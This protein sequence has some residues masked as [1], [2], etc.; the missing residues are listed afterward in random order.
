MYSSRE[1]TMLKTS[2][3]RNQRSKGL[4][5]KHVLQIFV[6]LATSLWLVNQLKH[7]YDKKE[8]F[9]DSSEKIPEEVR[10]EHEILKLGRKG[11]HT[12]EEMASNFESQGE[13]EEL[14]EETEDI[15]SEETENEGRGGGDDEID[16]HDQAEEEEPEEVEDLT[17][18]DDR[19]RDMN[20]EKVNIRNTNF[21]QDNTSRS[22]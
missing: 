16:G 2:P 18:V 13:N 12:R 4:K 8:G 11:L 10:N 14:E 3:S 6:L 22:T 5:V 21:G 7:S 9:K 19:E 15:K 1:P 17:D 20:T